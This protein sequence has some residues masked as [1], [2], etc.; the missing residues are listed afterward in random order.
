MN[1]LGIASDGGATAKQIQHERHPADNPNYPDAH[2][3]TNSEKGK[4]V[5]EQIESLSKGS[6]REQERARRLRNAQDIRRRIFQ[7]EDYHHAQPY[8]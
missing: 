4:W 3:R 5:Q 8:L 6:S 2:F 1:N 7:R